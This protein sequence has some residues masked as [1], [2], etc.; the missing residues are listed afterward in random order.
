LGDGGDGGTALGVDD[1]MADG[2]EAGM[3]SGSVMARSTP[4]DLED[5]GAV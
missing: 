1:E 4:G 2:K 5:P 3:T